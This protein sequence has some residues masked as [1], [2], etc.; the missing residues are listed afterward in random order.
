MSRVRKPKPPP[1]FE[2][3]AREAT[4]DDAWEDYRTRLQAENGGIAALVPTVY[5]MHP[6]EGWEPRAGYTSPRVERKRR[7]YA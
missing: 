2:A 6:P 7:R 3:W 1:E 4:R 5:A